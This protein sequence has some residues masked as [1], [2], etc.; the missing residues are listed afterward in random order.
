M[1][2]VLSLLA[3]I[4]SLSA[5]TLVCVHAKC[6]MCP[7][8]MYGWFLFDP[9]GAYCQSRYQPIGVDKITCPYGVRVNTPYQSDLVM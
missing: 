5:Y 8:T 6:A 4:T 3:I 7:S 2:T 1:K 9:G